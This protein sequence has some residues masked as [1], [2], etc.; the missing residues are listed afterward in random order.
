MGSGSTVGLLTVKELGGRMIVQLP[1]TCVIPSMP[2]SALKLNA[3]EESVLLELL[4][5]RLSEL[6]YETVGSQKATDMKVLRGDL[7]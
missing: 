5:K 7:N 4:P 6:V 1:E 2:E 3:T